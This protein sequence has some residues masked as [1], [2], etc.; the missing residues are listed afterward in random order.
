MAFAYIFRQDLQRLI[1]DVAKSIK[2]FYDSTHPLSYIILYLKSKKY[3]PT[4]LVS[5]NMPFQHAQN[6]NITQPN[7]KCTTSFFS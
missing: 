1:K 7:D 4:E 3:Y 6:F 5:Y 2:A